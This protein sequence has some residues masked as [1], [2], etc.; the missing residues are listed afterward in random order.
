[1]S[2]S[3]KRRRGEATDETQTH[4]QPEPEQHQSQNTE[5]NNRAGPG[6]TTNAT[7]RATAL[8]KTWQKTTPP[9][10]TSLIAVANDG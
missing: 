7:R 5:E 10:A 1:M 3:G 4:A 8:A 2:F 6:R 9:T